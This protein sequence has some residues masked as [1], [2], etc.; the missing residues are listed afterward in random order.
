MLPQN[1]AT[2]YV[3]SILKGT[4]AR[5]GYDIHGFVVSTRDEDR[6]TY[7]TNAAE[8]NRR[9]IELGHLTTAATE[10]AELSPVLGELDVWE[11]V[12]LQAR[13]VD[14][15]DEVLLGASQLVHAQ[16]VAEALETDGYGDELILTALIHDTG[17]VASLFGV[18]L[19]DLVGDPGPLGPAT[20]GSGLDN[21]AFR[22][23]HG[24]FLAARTRHVLPEHITW[25]VRHHSID[26]PKH[27]DLLTRTER[28]WC[29]RYLEPFIHYDNLSKSPC[30]LPRRRIEEYRDLV[31][32]AFP[33]PIVF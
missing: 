13:I 30:R 19:A 15:I 29:S 3:Q 20:P 9:H 1:R 6:R 18:D 25:V 8:L 24:T 2:R 23:S 33:E 11:L 21:C 22:H 32:A 28:E 12:L 26:L 31:R 14:P 10:A 27:R 17:K 7:A 16:Q 4:L 5:Y